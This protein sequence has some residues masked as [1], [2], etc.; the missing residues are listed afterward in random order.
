MVSGGRTIQCLSGTFTRKPANML[1][2]KITMVNG[3]N[4]KS[5]FIWDIHSKTC[6][7]ALRE[8]H[9]GE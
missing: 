8:D 2:G 1:L 7:H 4:D 5:V 3:A 9:Y 6:K